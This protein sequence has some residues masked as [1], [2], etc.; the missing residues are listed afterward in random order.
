MTTVRPVPAGPPAPGEGSEAGGPPRLRLL[1]MFR[2]AASSWVLALHLKDDLPFQPANSI[3]ANLVANGAYAMTFFFMLSGLVLA[4]GYID[5]DARPRGTSRFYIARL[6]RV[7]PA[8]A[9]IH[10][11]CLPWLAIP[12]SQSAAW[13]YVNAT[14]FLGISAWFPHA[15]MGANTATWSI[16]CEFFFYALFPAML[17][18]LRT[19]GEPRH[20]SRACL[21]LL[22]FIGFLG[23]ADFAFAGRE[24]FFYYTTPIMRLPEFVLGMLL[25]AS[26]RQ[27]TWT[28]RRPLW[29]VLLAGVAVIVACAN[30]AHRY[31]LWTRANVIVVPSFAALLY[32]S[33]A[34]ELSSGRIAE[35]RLGRTLYYLGESSYSV[36][37]THIPLVLVFRAALKSGATWAQPAVA[38]PLLTLLIMFIAMVATGILLHEAVEKPVRR[39]LV[40]RLLGR[41]PRLADP[42]AP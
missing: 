27:R 36:F 16:S 32:L 26:L 21:Y 40:R 22:L 10:I 38:H 19:W 5:V 4:Y 30:P 9:L 25:G 14:S 24:T 31:G 29:P 2:F 33:A 15:F 23:L 41:A 17:P 6:A 3:G 37:L 13:G 7:Y 1:T 35:G 42:A 12:L 20:F 34:Y 11:I 39:M 8:Y 28:T 18:L